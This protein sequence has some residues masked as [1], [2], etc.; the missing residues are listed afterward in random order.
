M[1]EQYDKLQMEV[2]CFE[3]EDII[4]NSLTCE[5]YVPDE[6]EGEMP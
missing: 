1:K 4:T 2:I 6:N 5:F 3:T